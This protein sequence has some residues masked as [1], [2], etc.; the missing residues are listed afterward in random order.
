M[1]RPLVE[2]RHALGRCDHR[3]SARRRRHCGP[4]ALAASAI[5]E[6]TTIPTC[7]L[8]ICLGGRAMVAT[9]FDGRPLAPEHGGPARLLV[10]PVLLEKREVD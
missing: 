10:P 6:T 3:R 2:V 1:R 8:P 5:A 4:D 9:H 7:Q